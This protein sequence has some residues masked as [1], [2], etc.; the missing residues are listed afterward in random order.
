MLLFEPFIIFL[1]FQFELE[2]SIICIF[3]RFPLKTF[4]ELGDHADNAIQESSAIRR[5]AIPIENVLETLRLRA[6]I[7]GLYSKSLATLIILFLVLSETL[8]SG[9]PD[10]TLETVET[11]T[12]AFK[13]IL[14]NVARSVT[15]DF[16]WLIGKIL[17]S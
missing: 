2:Y 14:F 7:F 8:W 9:F 10:S 1:I 4:F 17:S 11:S 5:K 16:F 3:P 15:C 13:A 6:L 12:F